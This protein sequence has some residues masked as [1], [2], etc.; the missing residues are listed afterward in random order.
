MTDPADPVEQAILAA[1]AGWPSGR[2]PTPR[3]LQQ[4]AA[5]DRSPELVSAAFWR[6]VERGT[7]VFDGSAR[8]KLNDIPRP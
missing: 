3:A 8:V 7:L 6:L 4:A 5:E 1:L 2:P